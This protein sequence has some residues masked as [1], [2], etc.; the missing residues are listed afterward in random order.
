MFSVSNFS[1]ADREGKQPC[2]TTDFLATVK[3]LRKTKVDL[4][5]SKCF[6]LVPNKDVTLKVSKMF[7]N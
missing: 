2:V 1:L 6:R 3:I 4:P 7:L 5:I